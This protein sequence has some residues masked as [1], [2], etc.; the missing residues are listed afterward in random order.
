MYNKSKKYL[1]VSNQIKLIVFKIVLNKILKTISIH[2]LS[3]FS[4]KKNFAVKL[5]KI[6]FFL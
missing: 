3:V 4:P 5:N 2:K 1:I 6:C